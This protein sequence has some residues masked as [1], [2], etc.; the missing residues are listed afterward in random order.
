MIKNCGKSI[1][2]LLFVMFHLV[3]CIKSE[4][5][6]DLFKKKLAVPVA[7]V[8]VAPVV[9]VV[10]PSLAILSIE[11]AVSETVGS[12]TFSLAK[13]PTNLAGFEFR[14]QSSEELDISTLVLA[15]FTN[16]GTG[17]SGSLSWTLS[18]CGD[19]KNFKLKVD[20]LSGEGTII[21]HLNANAVET[22]AG[23]GSNASLSIDGSITYDTVR[24]TLTIG[25]HASQLDPTGGVPVRFSVQFSEAIDPTTFT[26]HDIVLDGTST[27]TVSTWNIVNSGDN[28]NFT[29]EAMAV[30]ADG[31][32]V[33]II[34]GNAVKDFAGNFNFIAV[35]G[36]DN[37]VTINST[38]IAAPTLEQ[39]AGPNAATNSLPVEFLL[40]FNL[41]IN[42]ASF[43]TS[44]ITQAGTAPGVTWTIINTG[45]DQTFRIIANTATAN[46]TIRPSLSANAVSSAGGGLYAAAI[47]VGTGDTVRYDTIAP[48]VI[49]S[50]DPLQADPTASTPILFKA[51][52]SEAIDVST[53]SGADIVLNS[54]STGVVT[55]W[56]IVNS[57]DDRNFRLEAT[58]IGT[59]GTIIP[60]M[61][62]GKVFDK[63]S[64]SNALP[65]YGA[66]NQVTFDNSSPKAVINQHLGGVIGTCPS[67]TAQADPTNNQVISY[68]VTFN[69]I[70]NPATFTISD[71]TNNGTGGAGG[72]S[73]ALTSCGDNL[74]F[75]LRTSAITGGGTI[76]PRIA[77]SVL[78]DSLGN[79][80][81][82]STSSDGSV[83]FSLLNINLAINQHP[84]GVIGT[85][86]NI[87]TQVD[88]SLTIAPINYLMT[89]SSAINP[90]TLDASDILNSGTGGTS[91][92]TWSIT[93]CG[94]NLNFLLSTTAITGD[95]TIV[96]T[97]LADKVADLA[98]NINAPSS[99][100]DNSV[101][102]D[103]KGPA[104]SLEKYPGGTFGA[105]AL[106]P[107][108]QDP[109]RSLSIK[110]LVQFDEVILPETFHA[111]DIINVG[112]GGGSYLDWRITN[113]GDNKAYLL[114]AIAVEGDGDITPQ[115]NA[116]TVKDIYNND[117]SASFSIDNAVYYDS[118]APL[119][120]IQKHPGG[121][122]GTC[123]LISVQSGFTNDP[124][125]NFLLTTNEV[126]QPSSLSVEDIINTGN[127]G[128]G[129]LSWSIISCGDNKNFVL[130]VLS[131]NGGGDII[132]SINAFMVKDPYNNGNFASTS[133]SA[134]VKYD[135]DIPTLTL[136]QALNQ[137]DP[138]AG[139][140]IRF[141]VTFSEEINP[142]T[143]DVSDISLDASSTATVGNWIIINS[144]N[145]RDYTLEARNLSSTGMI[146][147][148]I[149]AGRVT[150]FVGFNNSASVSVDNEV[151]VE[152]GWYQEAYIKAPNPT[153]GDEFGSSLDLHEDTLIVGAPF[154]DSNQ[155][156]ITNGA[157]ASADNSML[158]SGAAYIYK[159]TGASW[160]PEAYLKAVNSTAS[161]QYGFE[162]ALSADTAV[163]GA[164]YEDATQITITNG[165]TADAS[166]IAN[167][168]GAVYVYKRSGTIWVQEAYIKAGNAEVNDLF[169][170]Q[171]S[172]DQDTIVVGVPIDDSTSTTIINGTTSHVYN[173]STSWPN[174]GSVFV[175]K[176]TGSNWVQE[177]YIKPGATD[178]YDNF[179]E[180]VSLSGDILA[181]GSPSEDSNTRTIINGTGLA[182]DNSGSGYG[183]VFIFKRSGVNWIQE[184]YLKASDASSSD[185]FGI[186]LSLYQH[187]LAVASPNE[188]SNQTTITQ[189]SAGL[190]DFSSSDSGAVYLY[191]RENGLWQ[192]E[193]YLKASN[194]DSSDMFGKVS[195]HEDALA[196]GVLKE[197]ALSNSITNGASASSDNSA[198]SSGAVYTY[199]RYNGI[200]YQDAYIKAS[201]GQANDE[202]GTDLR[203]YKET[204]VVSAPNEDSSSGQ[205]I[206][207]TYSDL[208]NSM[209]NSGAVYVYRNTIRRF[210]AIR[211]IAS[212][213]DESSITI[214]WAKTGAT[215]AGF[216]VAYQLGSVAPLNCQSG[217]V[218]DVGNLETFIASGLIERE[219]YSFR[220]CS[221]DGAG[222]LSQG[223]VVN[224]ST[225]DRLIEPSNLHLL[226]RSYNSID[227]KWSAGVVPANGFKVSYLTGT[228]APDEFCSNGTGIDVGTNQT[229]TLTPVN[230]SLSYSFRV[231]AY[232][233]SAIHSKGIILTV[234][235]GWYQEAYIKAAN[236]EA[237]DAFGSTLFMDGETL[238]VGA[239]GE[240]AIDAI[241]TNGPTAS[242]SNTS[243]ASG[244]TY[245][246]KRN[247]GL[248]EQEAYVKAVN[249]GAND[250]FGY[251]VAVD[252]DTL[253][254][255]AP[256]EDSGVITITN[257]ATA[258]VSETA[259]SSGAIYVYKRTG[260]SWAQEA[261]IKASNA[262]LNDNFGIRVAING[263]TVVATAN[264]EDS[265]Q[266][267]ITNGSANAS[268]DN[269]FLSSGA[270]YVYKRTGVTWAQ[271][272]YIKAS[273]ANASDSFGGS[274]L[275]LDGD[276]LAVGATNEDSNQT[277]ITSGSVASGDNSSLSSGAVYLYKRSQASWFEYG[278]VKASNNDAY[279]Y[280]GTSVALSGDTLAVSATSESANLATITNGATSSEDDTLASSGAVYIYTQNAGYWGQ[281]AYIKASNADASDSFGAG[282][283]LSGD[284]LAVGAPYEDSNQKNIS[285][286][287]TSSADNS[288]SNSGALYVYKRVNGIWTQESF[289]KPSGAT[290][291]DQFGKAINISGNT[292][293][294]G[295]SSDGHSEPGIK[296][297]SNFTRNNLAGS[298]GAAYV[299]RNFSRQFMPSRFAI[300]G[301]TGT[302]VTL[303]WTKV[304]NA[305]GYRISYQ[306]G[307]TAPVDCNSGT[308]LDVG[309]VDTYTFTGLSAIDYSF[310]ICSYDPTFA[311][312]TGYTLL[313]SGSA[314]TPFP[315]NPSSLAIANLLA[316]SFQVTWVAGAGGISGYKI[317]YLE[318]I[319]PP[320]DCFGGNTLDIGNVLNYSFTAMKNNTSYAVRICSYDGTG[321]MSTGA[322]ISTKTPDYPYDLSGLYLKNY[323][324][325]TATLAWTSA[326][327]ATTG[328]KIAYA[329]TTAPADCISGTIVD[330][331]NVVEYT[332]SSLT[333]ATDYAFRVCAYDVSSKMTIGSTVAKR[334]GWYQEAYIKAGNAE[335]QDY[336]GNTIALNKD[337]LVV[338]AP[339]EDSNQ[340]TITNGLGA[341]VDNTLTNSGA[342]YVYKRTGRE[343]V[344]EAFIKASNSGS[345]DFFGSAIALE[346]DSLVISAPNEDN[347]VTTIFNTPGE[348][349]D[350]NLNDSGAVYVYKRVGATWKQEAYIKS[351]N[352]TGNDRFGTSVSI[353]G[354]QLVVGA[355]GEDSNGS[356]I[357][358]GPTF[359]SD[360][361]YADTGAVYVYKKTNGKWAHE[362]YIKSR[363][364]SNSDAFGTSVLIKGDTIFANNPGEDSGE[365]IIYSGQSYV[366]STTAP[367]SGA[368][369]VFRKVNNLWTN[370]AFIKAGN[371]DDSDAFGVSFGY[372]DDLLAIGATGEDSIQTTITNGPGVSF[373]NLASSSGAVYVYKRT[374]NLWTQHAYLKASNARFND[375]FGSSVS[376]FGKTLAVGA[377]G[378]DGLQ[379]TIT[380][381]GAASSVIGKTDSGAVYLFTLAGDSWVQTA[382]IKPTNNESGFSFGTRVSL[383]EASLAVGAPYQYSTFKG[384]SYSES[385][386]EVFDNTTAAGAG[387]VYVF[388]NFSN[389]FD[390]L[391]LA[392]TSTHNSITLSWSKMGETYTG[393]KIS[394]LPGATAPI[395]CSSGTVVDVGNVATHTI[396]SLLDQRNYSFRVCAYNANGDLSI[397]VAHTAMTQVAPF[398][399]SAIQLVDRTETTIRLSWIHGGAPITGFKIAYQQSKTIP[400]NCSTGTVLDVG[401]VTTYELTGLEVRKEYG[402]RVCGYYTG[403]DTT[404][405]GLFVPDIGWYQEAY[406]KPSNNDS[407]E[408]WDFGY[409]LDVDQDTMVT[410]APEEPGSGTT[411]INGPVAS[412]QLYTTWD[413]GALYVYQRTG[414][415]WIQEAY[416][417]APNADSY[418]EMGW[419]VSIDGDRIVTSSIEEDA[420]TF[421]IT[422][423]PDPSQ[424]YL[425]STEDSGAVY[426]YK[427]TGVTWALEKY[428]KAT[429]NTNWVNFGESVALSGN[430]LAVGTSEEGHAQ[431]FITN[432]PLAPVI[433]W[434]ADGSG[435][436]HVFVFDGAD[437]K[438]QAYIKPS[439]SEAYD[440]FGYLIALQGNTLVS[441]A[442]G[443]D[444][445]Q[446]FITNGAVASSD[447]TL[448]ESGAAYVFNRQG[449][450]WKQQAYIKAVNAE[451]NDYFGGSISLDADRLAVGAPNEDSSDTSITNG[452][453]ASLDNSAIASG[454]TYIYHRKNDQWTQ[455]AYLK[456]FNAEANDQFGNSVSLSGNRL[457]IGAPNEDSDY[458]E[459][460]NVGIPSDNDNKSNSGAVYIYTRAGGTWVH[461]SFI[462]AVNADPDDKFG[463]TVALNG[464]TLAVHS[465]GEDSISTQIINGRTA[466]MDNEW[467]NVGAVYIYRN[468]IDKHAPTKV[469]AVDTLSKSITLRWTKRAEDSG[470]K[471][472]YLMGGTPPVSCNGA[473]AI[474]VG[475][476]DNHTFTNLQPNVQYSFIICAYNGS[477]VL[478]AAQTL[479]QKTLGPPIG[480]ILLM[481]N[482]VKAT[483]MLLQWEN[484]ITGSAGF[485]VA[486]KTGSLPPLNCTSETNLD[487][488]SVT[489]YRMSSLISGNLYSARVCP[490]DSFGVM[491]VG[492]VVTASTLVDVWYQESFIK[493]ANSDP[494]DSFGSSV[495]IYADTL[496]VGAPE[497]DSNLS[498][499]TNGATSSSNNFLDGSG[500]VYV[501]KRNFEDWKQAAYLKSPNNNKGDLFGSVVKVHNQTLVA[502]APLEDSNQST[503]VNGTT[504]SAD[505]SLSA[506]GGVFVFT[507]NDSELWSQQA[508]IKSPTPD[509]GDEFGSNMALHQNTLIVA[510][511]REDSNQTSITNGVGGSADNTLLD[512]GA[513]YV[514]QRTGVTWGQEAYVKAGNAHATA[515]YGKAVGLDTDT[516]VIGAPR[517]DSAQSTI[518]NGVG[519]ALDHNS[520]GSGAVY[521]YKRTGAAWIQEAYIKAKN[522]NSVDYFGA[523]VDIRGDLLAVGAPRE[524]SNETVITIGT[525]ASSDNN[526]TDAGAVY[527]YQRTGASW[528]QVA[529]VK[530]PNSDPDDQFG[531]SLKLGQDTLVVGSPLEDSNQDGVSVSSS[532]L[533]DA[534]NAGAVYVFKKVGVN[535]LSESYIKPAHSD[536]GD[537]FGHALSMSGDTIVI[538]APGESSAEYVITN[539]QNA[540][541][542][543]DSSQ[544]GAVYVYRYI[545]RKFDVV[546]LTASDNLNGDIE[547]RW[548][549][550]AYAYG[551]KIAYQLGATAPI[552]C[553]T[554]TILDA[555]SED[556]Y[557]VTGLTPGATY[558]FRVCGY[559]ESGQLSPGATITASRA[560]PP[561]NPTGLVLQPDNSQQISLS[562]VSGGGTTTGFKIAYLEGTTAPQTC[563]A[564]TTADV[565][566]V[567]AAV[568]S[569]F[570]HYA[571]ISVRVCAYNLAGTL[572]SGITQTKKAEIS[573]WYQEAYIKPNTNFDGE[574]EFGYQTLAL[575]AD[576]II[577][578]SIYENNNITEIVHG[579]TS[580]FDQNNNSY[581]VGA[582]WVFERTGNNWAQTAYLKPSSIDSSDEFGSSAS[583][584]GNL[585]AISATND[586]S[587]LLTITN[588]EA[589]TIN[590]SST[591]SGAIYL[592]RK[593][594]GLWKQEAQLKGSKA[595][596]S[597]STWDGDGYGDNVVVSGNSV[598]VSA[599]NEDGNQNTITNGPTSTTTNTVQGSGA[600]FV[601]RNKGLGWYQEAYIKAAN[602]TSFDNFGTS[603]WFDQATLAVGAPFEDSS[604][605]TITNG[606]AVVENNVAPNAGA[607]YVYRRTGDLWAQEAYIKASNS[608]AND[609]YGSDVSIHGDL[610]TVTAPEEASAQST[611]TNGTGSATDNLWYG[612]GAVYVYRR[613]GTTWAQEAYIKLSGTGIHPNWYAG[614][615]SV[616][617]YG[618][619]IVVGNP[620]DPSIQNVILN[621]PY[622]SAYGDG[623][624]S[625]D[626][627]SAY[628]YRKGG[629]GWYQ[630]AYI[631][632]SNAYLENEFGSE[633]RVKGDTIA[634][635]SPFEGVASTTIV[636]GPNAPFANQLWTYRGA[637]YVYRNKS[638]LFEPVEALANN[639]TKD[640]VE[641]KWTA[642]SGSATGT[643]I[644]YQV[645]TTPP[646]DCNSGTVLDAGAL[647][648]AIVSG[649]LPNTT[650]SFRVCSYDVSGNL[651][652]G[653]TFTETTTTSSPEVTQLAVK[654]NSTDS[655]SLSWVSG[656]GAT[657]GF[658]VAY[659][660]VSTPPT[661][662]NTGTVVDVGNVNS[663]TITALVAGSTQAI[664]VCSYDAGAALSRGVKVHGQVN[665]VGWNFSARFK[666]DVQKYDSQFGELIKMS[667][668]TIAVAVKND[669]SNQSI[670]TTASNLDK[671]ELMS[672]AVFI[673][674]NNAGNW[675]QEA[676]IKADNAEAGDQFGYAIDLYRGK[677][678]VGVPLEDSNQST[679][680]NGST[681]SSNN[682]ELDSGAVYIY[683][684]TGAV[685]SQEAYLKASNVESDDRYGYSVAL[686]KDLLLVG[687]TKEDSDQITITNGVGASVDNSITD[688]GAAYLYGFNG[689]A[690]S[691]EAYLKVDTSQYIDLFGQAVA[692]S[693]ND[694]LAVSSMMEDANVLTI[695]N[696]ATS[697]LDNSAANSG[698]VYVY[699]K[700]SGS[701]A[702][703][704]YIKAANNEA[705][706]N[707][708]RAI[709]L[710]L[711]TLIV[712]NY[713]DDSN[714]SVIINGTT[715]SGTNSF[716]DFGSVFVYRRQGTLWAQEAYLKPTNAANNSYGFFGE[717][718]A[719]SGDTIV[720]GS[721]MENSN[722]K[723]ITNGAA[724]SGDQSSPDSGAAY[725]FR[726]VGTNWSQEAYIKSPFNDPD[727]R[728]GKSVDILGN[729]IVVGS[730]NDAGGGITNTNSI[731][732]SLNDLR[733]TKTGSVYLFENNARL[734]EV[735][736]FESSVD[737]SSATFNWTNPKGKLMGVKYVYQIGAVAPADC[738]TGATDVLAAETATVTGL[739]SSTTYSFRV[740][741]YDSLSALSAGL[742]ITLTTL[743]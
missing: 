569:G 646:A 275:S 706:D 214:N 362:A 726:R 682:D 401:N 346:D 400:A 733:Q 711:D 285:N 628:V 51:V 175:Y 684:R 77:A 113:C 364:N 488:G 86:S 293:V 547:L 585:A 37:S 272:A 742:T 575:G 370:E 154:E 736:E 112:S 602:I 689:A 528:A 562:W 704:A 227:I 550:L 466:A 583:I 712:N 151:S 63:A 327:G 543:N 654:S 7:N 87:T 669:N 239:T 454:A 60:N 211:L 167:D 337:T 58:S 197:G 690:W 538:G 136:N 16:L 429:N 478:G 98:G 665:N 278:Y 225:T 456:A 140:P 47:P 248:W 591:D 620:D 156:T 606:A 185:A 198:L 719:I 189:G 123:P 653:I 565:G 448:T 453:S 530:A 343:W 246:Y 97:I 380:N 368:V 735:A 420:P 555:G 209:A 357:T 345:L 587:S 636:N 312:N 476:V 438:Q 610:L 672:G 291:G 414:A 207:S 573:G 201:N 83:L 242:S 153:A 464:D 467:G 509:I 647:E 493:V 46:G 490:Y 432:G 691:Q 271:E 681:A 567:S 416:I 213:R 397:G 319:L 487:V 165:P 597:E 447:N 99:S 596:N 160:A 553:Q 315:S 692:I 366:N 320:A 433:D 535:W 203:L 381:G 79:F 217:T 39:Q 659:A 61:Q 556:H 629:S 450:V 648:S 205:I 350:N 363:S 88:P 731:D 128:A 635:T 257:G 204:L 679:I 281:Q 617:V 208:D 536:G 661:D 104:I 514:F 186:N 374:N 90:T 155:S 412:A 111:N 29:I 518:T 534:A 44:D 6:V 280:F 645:G 369:L 529:Y 627:G 700:T 639:I 460:T 66:D 708:G 589:T 132:P 551:Y 304:L 425:D 237:S 55:S 688:S 250:N 494:F 4:T 600:V 468:N 729:I 701:W 184:A 299:F 389:L 434:N 168:T 421:V 243:N 347:S 169:G 705:G 295:V 415:N 33:P 431:N 141:T 581:R 182:T 252:K 325:T 563:S 554:G 30:G 333:P 545:G 423:A 516:L 428:L 531:H 218:V 379:N 576:T 119:L 302:D 561:P 486:F 720:A 65:T 166:N 548:N 67:V 409:A 693:G 78:Q 696:G 202:F 146:K 396:A 106:I 301:D 439:N 544:S 277:S 42:Q 200:W 540:S 273:N 670:I 470:Y 303:T 574:L 124:N 483:S 463:T 270:V 23:K 475:W 313:R 172:I 341:S 739:S 668:D 17:G 499:I 732:T 267:T 35:P 513:V 658:K 419:T 228:T 533:N 192:Q 611:I 699:R 663:Y 446:N 222:I 226:G 632:A 737:S 89:F 471:I 53:F 194:A 680:T 618:D 734:F 230:T 422:D 308:N 410:S 593:V 568:I 683:K 191:Q 254:V 671:S 385:M 110:Y 730:P 377:P 560:N 372:S 559:D 68:L 613:N 673:F 54:S 305:T 358:N 82:A 234:N 64:N 28:R 492:A 263:N 445:N 324:A 728:F 402:I 95:G 601:Y 395:D 179:G 455:E 114:E 427:R 261:Y 724:S 459:V 247:G 122:I 621:G 481:A 506:S 406:I 195:L 290:A 49:F 361:F 592:F 342:A 31:Q 294:V 367:D 462:K 570:K 45:D 81:S 442:T 348:S 161:D 229:Y 498:V 595:L 638:R 199:H 70:I 727:D 174:Y 353:S 138:T 609:Y 330:V 108:Q 57:G 584:D 558:S 360:N 258:P 387:A 286:T 441:T 443:E 715:A 511:S 354:D 500:A 652:A 552:N 238:V 220:V 444:A 15:D 721:S 27:T 501:F 608:E 298:S 399:V 714:S 398:E 344:Q 143:F 117:N 268:P 622:P 289:I 322:L 678:A 159:R 655:L 323:T 590:N 532:A 449:T 133:V 649:L 173:G 741:T 121:I 335:Y 20:A 413:S 139:V 630:E 687:A 664:F 557:I 74:N 206:N 740:C 148:K 356:G 76:V 524:D 244:A 411:I 158:D 384:I 212:A 718:L 642:N 284:T 435:A 526:G 405:A 126:I 43:V 404:G 296:V 457:A 100:T 662:C 599:R 259:P 480:P 546:K 334:E 216:K 710:S 637:I 40:H 236:A 152:Q 38:L 479:T 352:L 572:S 633:V 417:K 274:G 269:S 84:G 507:E 430:T 24:P 473:S 451:K 650:Y 297:G 102:Y 437:W 265:N 716:Q 149:L 145:N 338:G 703:E 643:K 541:L 18:H 256:Y 336:F 253:V 94:D 144:G 667:E 365:D 72:L 163:I 508:F 233:G 326:G 306:S 262:Q 408:I 436:V 73:W 283:A 651:S 523:A 495:D 62:A 657:T 378:Q 135:Q 339:N 391:N 515:L 373:D 386:P 612:A 603:I 288:L 340:Q 282:I 624:E 484:D 187:R 697:S 723:T 382:F 598:A 101:L 656:G 604:Q 219:N 677:L 403:I 496:V 694:T 623:N 674:R 69:K 251:A 743:P 14:I 392:S 461:E 317:N 614:I 125:I 686:N 316:D 641:I 127:G 34:P 709:D 426:I 188:D 355:P 359:A 85:C 328:F 13:D 240:D 93:S 232:D 625:W 371:S 311:M 255:G 675:D 519:V 215:T 542:N 26:F 231:C 260:V 666:A 142:A 264:G 287:A 505:N 92:L 10:D 180:G 1:Y 440:G 394:Y 245:I 3:G 458:T 109:S 25:Q 48:T 522:N 164:P 105:C 580:T 375:Y 210:E 56:N 482:D 190:D 539:S 41:P 424:I 118:S 241:I 503:I 695:T 131:I 578:T 96:P 11:Q 605:N 279:D 517:E 520:A 80:N 388:R 183:A 713:G 115:I 549:R 594:A 474:D 181:V 235:A 660:D 616:S 485:R 177:A 71:V 349:D 525:N 579:P 702:Q 59:S 307:M 176:R 418:D 5:K 738:N 717:S 376:L 223:I 351:L 129:G 502:S 631:Q 36:A 722:Q 564:G 249:N 130:N 582:A 21:P 472:D 147:V 676:F 393:F 91:Q 150:D 318:G 8:P 452:E 407:G 497:E 566:N 504:A 314:V 2:L 292:I 477:G 178:R 489:S 465:S 52:F 619:T 266:S 75:L 725:V 9:P 137:S 586:D 221:Y 640:S 19:N 196:V 577:G 157:T 527:L 116:A 276:L 383:S 685:W 107:S 644:V 615:A 171:I 309:D 390:P 321:N 332:I 634:V 300:N 510:A 162:V 329:Q 331:G 32:I 698:A 512:S 571:K 588:G 469:V 103:V 170:S 310:R 224:S 193:A 607:V 537:L 50:Q 12:C 491:G 707:F 22:L 134:L 521:V 626:V 120:T